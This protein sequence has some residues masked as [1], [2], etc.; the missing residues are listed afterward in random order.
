M[1]NDI[2]LP[3]GYEALEAFVADW[4]IA[5]LAERA[6]RRDESTPEE[7]SMLYHAVKPV[8]PAA[9]AEL[10]RKPLSQ[11]D[12][13]EQRLLHLLL[14]Y[15]QVALAIEIRGDGEA[16]HAQQRQHMVITH[17]PAGCRQTM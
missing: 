8:A 6:R 17:E 11:L 10:D 16:A 2:S 15:A 7:R 12:Q 13:G 4:S 14:S 1:S 5:S 9:L 3:E